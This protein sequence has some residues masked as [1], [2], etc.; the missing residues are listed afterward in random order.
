MQIV[1]TRF[2]D[3]IYH[4][5]AGTTI[6]R[7]IT[8][9][10]N[11]ELLHRVLTDLEILAADKIIVRV[12]AIDGYVDVTS[13]AS[14]YRDCADT[15]LGAVEAGS[16]TLA[17]I[18]RHGRQYRQL[19]EIPAIAGQ[20]VELFLGDHRLNSRVLNIDRRSLSTHIN[21]RLN[22]SERHGEIHSRGGSDINGDC[23]LLLVRETLVLRKNLIPTRWQVKEQVL[24]A[25]V[26]CRRTPCPGRNV[27]REH[28]NPLQNR[29]RGVLNNTL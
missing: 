2:G 20:R 27:G 29:S 23:L 19:L 24:T 6:F 12:T 3:D 21:D 13:G 17:T 15:S 4:T 18:V 26:R 28:L 25:V 11:I 7:V 9:R 10:N 22:F 1:R 16:D 14:S 5:L 8:L